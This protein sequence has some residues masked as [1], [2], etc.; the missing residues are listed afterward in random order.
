[1]TKI[2]LPC[3]KEGGC[4][5]S[6]C[7]KC[8]DGSLRQDEG[9]DSAIP[10]WRRGAVVMGSA[11]VSPGSDRQSDGNQT[12]SKTRPEEAAG[13]DDDVAGLGNA[14]T[15]STDTTNSY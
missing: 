12:P 3:S 9:K 15:G 10:P 1:M 6:Y 13:P 7:G 8:Y 2:I 11:M 5:G 4:C 14:F